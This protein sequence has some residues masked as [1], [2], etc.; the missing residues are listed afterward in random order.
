MT[1]DTTPSIEATLDALER[2]LDEL[3]LD[4]LD[5][6]AG[7]GKLTLEKEDSG[8]PLILSRQGATNEIWLAEPR[9]GWHFAWDGSAWICTKRGVELL[10]ALEE[11]LEQA[12]GTKVSLR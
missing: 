12:L 1:P 10:A 9:G 5:I 7:D 4:D 6:E 2:K 8:R 3:E 11:L